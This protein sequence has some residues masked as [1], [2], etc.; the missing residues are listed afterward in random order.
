[1]EKKS[2]SLLDAP[3]VRFFLMILATVMLN[4]GLF[5][6]LNFLA[7][8][9]AG[10]IVGFLV[11]K[12]RDGVVIGFLG[13]VFSYSIIFVISQWFLGFVDAPL[14]VVIAV[15]IMG[16]LGAVGGLTGSVIS[17]KTRG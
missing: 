10:L 7:P 13:N 9:V 16:A 4:F 17:K 12:M 15:L 3:I 8:L 1:M 6:I 14:D 11:A 5:F 2:S